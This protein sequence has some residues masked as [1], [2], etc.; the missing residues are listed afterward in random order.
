[1]FPN[2]TMWIP[3]IYIATVSCHIMLV[4][5]LIKN[6]SFQFKTLPTSHWNVSFLRFDTEI[7]QIASFPKDTVVFIYMYYGLFQKISKRGFMTWNFKVY[8]RAYGNSRDQEQ[9]FH[10]IKKK[11]WNFHGSRFLVLEFQGWSFVF[12]R[13]SNGKVTNLKITWIFFEKSMSQL[14]DWIFSWTAEY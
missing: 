6:K 14:L 7:N 5:L 13:I 10:L 9:N 4:G 11:S 8:S 2:E 3:Y 1:M 12:S